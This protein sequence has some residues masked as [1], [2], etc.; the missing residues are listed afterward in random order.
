MKHVDQAGSMLNVFSQA[1]Q[2]EIWYAQ[3]AGRYGI[4]RSGQSWENPL[5]VLNE[6]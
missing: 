1:K 2:T 3:Q 5:L 4:A 6:L